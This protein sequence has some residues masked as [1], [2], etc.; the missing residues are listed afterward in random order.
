MGLRLGVSS[1]I[2][3]SDDENEEVLTKAVSEYEN[4][5]GETPTKNDP[6]V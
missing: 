2:F 1:E 4:S 3:P 6:L 5:A